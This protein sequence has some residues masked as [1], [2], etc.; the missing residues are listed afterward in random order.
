MAEQPSYR[1]LQESDFFADHRSA[2]PLVP[3]TVARGHLED[4]PHFFTGKSSDATHWKYRV[5]AMVGAGNLLPVLGTA[6]AEAEYV[7]TFAFAITQEVLER[8]R[9]RYGIF[10]AVC[11]DERGTGRGKIVERGF[12]QPPSFHTDLSRG[13]ERRG[14]RVPLREA[15]VGYY[16]DVITHGYGAMPDYAAQVPPRDR[17]AIIAYIRAL[18]FSE[19]ARLG[20]LPEE[21]K[22]AVLEHLGNVPLA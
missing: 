10:C 9:E 22:K 16:F 15:P 6:V 18:Q 21:E 13:L 3:G 12:T 17:W 4:D 19:R 2:R 8:G 1:P 14:I 5:P 11:H 20:D 7:D